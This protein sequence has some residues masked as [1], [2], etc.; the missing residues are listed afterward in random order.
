MLV[1]R[2][3]GWELPERAATPE[4]MMFGRRGM[5]AGAGA[6][7]ATL[8]LP[9]PAAAQ[10]APMNAKYPPGR[11]ITAEKEATTYNNYYEFGSQ[12]EIWQAAQAL[13][14]SPWS[15]KLDGIVRS[16]RTI[17]LEDLLKDR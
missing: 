8:A 4:Q 7:A 16:P 13:K 9:G 11:A 10:Q 15:I 17:A 6:L 5:L 3:R 12:K 2:R 1:L 14:V